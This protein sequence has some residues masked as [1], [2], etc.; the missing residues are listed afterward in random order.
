MIGLEPAG[1]PG[2]RVRHRDF[3]AR[4][5]R[6][7]AAARADARFAVRTGLA[8][9]D[10]VSV[11][12]VDFLTVREDEVWLLPARGAVPVFVVRQAR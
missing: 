6:I 7:D 11:E 2:Y 8:D 4:V 12:S 9:G 3:A 10:C 5:D 1:R